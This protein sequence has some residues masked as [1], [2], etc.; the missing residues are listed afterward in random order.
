MSKPTLLKPTTEI[1]NSKSVANNFLTLHERQLAYYQKRN[2]IFNNPNY[3]FSKNLRNIPKIRYKSKLKKTLYK[4][5]DS[6]MLQ[7]SEDDRVFLSVKIGNEFVNGLVDSGA[8]ITCLG[9]DSLDFIKRNNFEIIPLNATLK[10]A[11]GNKKDILGY[12]DVPIVFRKVTANFPIFI[13]PDLKQKLYLGTNFIRHF[14]LAPLLFPSTNISELS[15][16][17]PNK[18]S[19]SS[20]EEKMLSE[21]VSLFP[22]SETLGLGKTDFE[23]HIIDTG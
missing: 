11:G 22:S 2:E 16:V 17:D 3:N 1:D 12:V 6:T 13:A 21:I 23:T 9:N 20:A 18:H 14:Q 10:T 4:A 8:N 15:V 19:L 7:D 5:I